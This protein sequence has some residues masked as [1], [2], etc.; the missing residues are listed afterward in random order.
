[1]RLSRLSSFSTSDARNSNAVNHAT[2]NF[3]A[4]RKKKGQKGKDV[5]MIIRGIDYA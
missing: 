5:T 2:Q 4:H 3:S 1:V